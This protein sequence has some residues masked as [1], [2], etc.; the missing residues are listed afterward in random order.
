MSTL[1]ESTNESAAASVISFPFVILGL[2]LFVANQL[3]TKKPSKVIL[4]VLRVRYST[5]STPRS[6]ALFFVRQQWVRGMEVEDLIRYPEI[7]RALAPHLDSIPYRESLHSSSLES[8]NYMLTAVTRLLNYD[9]P[10]ASSFTQMRKN[11][12]VTLVALLK[13]L[14]NVI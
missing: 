10:S 9:T 1:S 7:T 13:C 14:A 11:A 12:E 8:V 4:S 2:S 6:V 3:A 5:H